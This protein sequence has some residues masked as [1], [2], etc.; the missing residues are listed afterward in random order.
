MTLNRKSY[1]LL[2]VCFF[3]CSVPA[4]FGQ[5]ASFAES[6]TGES[7]AGV[8]CENYS[9]TKLK[10]YCTGSWASG[11]N[12]G[13]ERA[14]A[15]NGFG[16]MK[17]YSY[18][19]L[20]L[21]GGG[22]GSDS[23]PVSEVVIDYLSIFG[24]NGEPTAFLKLEF[25]CLECVKE[26]YPYAFYDAYAG[27]YGPCEIYSGTSPICTLRVP[28]SYNTE[29]QPYPVSL[30]RQLQVNAITNVVNAPPGV[31]VTTTVCIGY[32]DCNSGATV[33]ASVVNAKGI[34]F[35]GVTVVG[36]SGHFYN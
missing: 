8:N 9:A 30:Q 24:L 6:V 19:S 32:I 18:S 28:I 23:A 26:V 3:F 1:L 33:K 21:A 22:D 25:E 36:A 7:Q 35:K 29:E 27:A 2:V 16:T 34:V 4:M 20:T 11:T 14:L 12:E 15:Q 13:Y 5:Q 10:I 17:A 31:T